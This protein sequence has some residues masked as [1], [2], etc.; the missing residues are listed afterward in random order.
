MLQLLTRILRYNT[1]SNL[2]NLLL[3]NKQTILSIT[4]CWMKIDLL[5]LI[6]DLTKFMLI[7][8]STSTSF[9]FS[10]NAKTKEKKILRERSSSFWF[11]AS[12]SFLNVFDYVYWPQ[13][14]NFKKNRF[15]AST[16]LLQKKSSLHSFFHFQ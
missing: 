11:K 16:R 5:K 7:K 14:E 12:L 6:K 1:F 2:F 3:V 8:I 13:K 9:L 4:F 15:L 10:C